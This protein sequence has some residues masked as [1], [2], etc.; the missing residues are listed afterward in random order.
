MQGLTNGIN[1][2]NVLLKSGDQRI[3]TPV[4]VE[5]DLSVPKGVHVNGLYNGGDFDAMISDLV[6]LKFNCGHTP[7]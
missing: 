5:G 7:N 2:S 6:S 1:M 3:E 4:H